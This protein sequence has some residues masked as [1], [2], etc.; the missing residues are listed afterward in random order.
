MNH[1]QKV[2][3]PSTSL[4]LVLLSYCASFSASHYIFS[5]WQSSV[6]FDGLV[7]WVHSFPPWQGRVPWPRNHYRYFCQASILTI[8][9]CAQGRDDAGAYAAVLSRRWG[10]TSREFITRPRQGDKRVICAGCISLDCDRENHQAT[11]TTLNSILDPWCLWRASRASH[12]SSMLLIQAC[13]IVLD[14]CQ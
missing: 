10:R 4:K 8:S 7:T 14:S 3:S 1:V 13:I 2:P 9:A 5:M 6:S 12:C 11:W